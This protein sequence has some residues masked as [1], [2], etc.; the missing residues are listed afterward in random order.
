MQ[1]YLFVCNT[2]GGRGNLP[3]IS[4]FGGADLAIDG[5]VLE[6]GDDQGHVDGAPATSINGAWPV[7]QK[8]EKEDYRGKKGG[9]NS[10]AFLAALS[11]TRPKSGDH[12]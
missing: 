10:S 6:V 8:R 7:K 4:N 9:G 5:G 1:F 2:F 11:C 12:R 3:S